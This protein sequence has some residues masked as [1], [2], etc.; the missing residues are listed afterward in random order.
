[1]PWEPA[2]PPDSLTRHSY[3]RRLRHYAEEW[4][5]GTGFAFFVFSRAEDGLRGGV[6]LTNVRRGV[7]ETGTLG[8]W[9][10]APFARQGIMTEGLGCVIEYAFERLRLHRLEAACLPRNEASRKVLAKCGFREEGF[11]PKF[12][13]INGDWED[14]LLFALLAEEAMKR[15]LSRQDGAETPHSTVRALR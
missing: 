10:G 15:R 3:R 5:S 9:V 1:M 7:A 6:T 4:R 12:L 14:H 13:R 2:W 8:Y 11:A